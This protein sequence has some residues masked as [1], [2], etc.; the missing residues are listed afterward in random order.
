LE[1]K[2]K[3]KSQNSF[4]TTYIVGGSVALE[5]A[6]MDFHIGTR[7]SINSSA[8]EVAC[9]A[10]PGIGAKKVQESSETNLQLLTS[11]AVLL[12]KVLS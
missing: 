4:G 3:G 7:L 12:S 5:G 8:L 6:I 2:A 9:P 1:R 11:G 10:P